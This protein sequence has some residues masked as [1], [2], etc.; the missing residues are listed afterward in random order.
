[1]LIAVLLAQFTAPVEAGGLAV[2][3][4]RTEPEKTCWFG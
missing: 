1:M 3:L 2:R 4:E